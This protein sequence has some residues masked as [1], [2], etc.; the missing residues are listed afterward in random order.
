MIT[1]GEPDSDHYLPVL[2]LV[3]RCQ[4]SGIEVIGL[5][6]NVQS[7]ER[8]FAQSVVITELQALKSALF[9]LTRHWLFA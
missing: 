6:I 8:L 3:K 9:G 4:Q 1:D 2:D 5:G 7:V